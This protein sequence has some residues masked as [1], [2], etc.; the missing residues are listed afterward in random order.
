M[1]YWSP[2]NIDRFRRDAKRDIHAWSTVHY[3]SGEYRVGGDAGGRM[4]MC[5]RI[6]R[7]YENIIQPCAVSGELKGFSGGGEQAKEF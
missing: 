4:E 5:W 1:L 7:E 3:A 2:E 6:K